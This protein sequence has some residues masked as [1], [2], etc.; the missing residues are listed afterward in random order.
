[1]EGEETKRAM[2]YMLFLSALIAFILYIA[3][4]LCGNEDLLTSSF[5]KILT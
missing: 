4:A 3:L 1:M 5:A 2:F